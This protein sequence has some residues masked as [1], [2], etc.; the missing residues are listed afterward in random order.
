MDVLGEVEPIYETLPGWNG[1]I[2]GVRRFEDLPRE[3]QNY[4]KTLEKLVGAP[5]KIVSVGAERSAT[6]IR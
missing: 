5:I 2:T 6:L 1:N 4:V 3:A